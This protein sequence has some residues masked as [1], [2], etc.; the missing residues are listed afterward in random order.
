MLHL[1]E[2]S[3]PL[4]RLHDGLALLHLAHDADAV[5]RGRFGKEGDAVFL[6]ESNAVRY[7]AEPLIGKG[8]R[9]IHMVNIQHH[10]P[11]GH[12]VGGLA[13]VVLETLRVEIDHGQLLLEARHLIGVFAVEQHDL[14]AYLLHKRRL[15]NRLQV[16]GGNR[17][18]YLFLYG[19]GKTDSWYHRKIRILVV[20]G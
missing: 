15:H 5:V 19:V 8:F 16:F 18:G 4:L 7:Y 12:G 11:G 17:G 10:E 13:E 9:I 6:A 3:E 2:V 14:V 20:S 1:E